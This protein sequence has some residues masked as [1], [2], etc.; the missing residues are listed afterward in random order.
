MNGWEE[1]RL[2]W[3]DSTPHHPKLADGALGIALWVPERISLER[4]KNRVPVFGTVRLSAAE[5]KDLAIEDGHPIRAAVLGLVTDGFYDP[6]VG[7]VMGQ[8]PL[9]PPQ[10]GVM[11][12]GQFAVDL[13]E[14][15]RVKPSRGRYFV[16][17]SVGSWTVGAF[18]I[19]V[20]A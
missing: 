4:S 20:V 11:V 6:H 10:T 14:V 18:P 5:L 16:F 19:E 3:F 12:S 8:A 1:I 15:V 2:P 9:F 17:G 7:N 13:F